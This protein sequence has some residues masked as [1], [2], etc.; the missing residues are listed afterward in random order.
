M[1]VV[2]MEKSA[3]P[4]LNAMV[5]VTERHP[6]WALP[7]G[8]IARLGQGSVRNMAVS[9]DG[10]LLA[11]ST[12]IG[13]W[14]YELDTMQLV[15]LWETGRGMVSAI[16]F[17]PRWALGCCRQRR[18]NCQGMASGPRGVHSGDGTPDKG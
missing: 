12:K 2:A 5:P 15:A 16:S 17:F 1:G 3:A 18:W 13:L 6:L 11:V 9:P 7:D 8:A 10:S 14:W 4:I